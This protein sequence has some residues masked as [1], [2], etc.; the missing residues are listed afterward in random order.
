MKTNCVTS[1]QKKSK[2]YQDMLDMFN[3]TS[4]DL[5]LILQEYQSLPENQELFERGELPFP[6]EQYVQGHYLG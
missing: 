3:M 4:G 5:E 1:L 2:E 6:S